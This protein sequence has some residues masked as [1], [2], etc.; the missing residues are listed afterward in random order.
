MNAKKT[1]NG[2]G[3]FCYSLDGKAVR[4][5]SKREFKYMLVAIGSDGKGRFIGLGNNATTLMSSW[6][7]LF[8]GCNLKVITIA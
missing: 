1:N 4:K 5:A 2:N 7:H 8:E 3:T 6:K